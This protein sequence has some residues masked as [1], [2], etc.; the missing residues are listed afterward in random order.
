MIRVRLRRAGDV[1]G[2]SVIM[3]ELFCKHRVKIA[4]QTLA[5]RVQV[6]AVTSQQLFRSKTLTVHLL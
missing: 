5:A 3:L 1:L 2:N 4:W 6:I